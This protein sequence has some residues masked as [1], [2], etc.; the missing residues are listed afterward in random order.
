[1]TVVSCARPGILARVWAEALAAARRPALTDNVDPERFPAGMPVLTPAQSTE[2]REHLAEHS[3][4]WQWLNDRL[5]PGSQQLLFKRLVFYVLG[6]VRA[7]IGPSP[8]QLRELL[9]TADEQ[10]VTARDVTPLA[11]AGSPSSHL[12]DLRP[13]GF[14]VTLESYMLGVQGTFQLQQYR[15]PTHAAARPK[16]GDIAIDAGGCFGET[17]L[18]LANAVGVNGRVVTLEFELANLV[19]LRANLAR[20]PSLASRI[21][22]VEGALW[23]RGGGGLQI[24]MSGP[25]ATVSAGDVPVADAAAGPVARSVALDDLVAD[26]VI[27][28]VDFV[29]F[30]IE[31]AE[32]MALVGATR[33]LERFRPRLALA[34]YHDIDHLWQLPR[35]LTSLELGYRFGL[36]HFTIH[37]EETVLYGWVPV[38]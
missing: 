34:G 26:G 4:E 19:L 5:D 33:V 1:M 29:K 8:D 35:F 11:Y 37:D 10:L 15:C 20:N 14:P 9:R 25:A 3:A 31:G 17:A 2:R 13:L 22:L 38:D 18:W 36:G 12:F 6:H 7:R 16:L 24:A 23:S 27:D 30:D 28:R 21:T 32:P